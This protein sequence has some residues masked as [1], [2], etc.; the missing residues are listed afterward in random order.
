MRLRKCL[1]RLAVDGPARSLGR[2]LGPSELNEISIVA[3]LGIDESEI[4]HHISVQIVNPAEV[5]PKSSSGSKLAPVV[6]LEQE[7][8]TLP[9]ALGGLTVLTPRRLQFSHLR[10]SYSGRRLARQGLRKPLD[11]LSRYAEMRNDFFL[12][13]AKNRNASDILKTYSSMDPI[14]ANNLYTK[15]Q[16]SDE[17]VVTSKMTLNELLI[18]V[19]TKGMSAFMTGIEIV[20]DSSNTN[21]KNHQE[22]SP[23][24]NLQYSGTALFKEDRM[25][26]WL[27]ENGDEALN[28]VH[29]SIKWAAGPSALSG[30]RTATFGGICSI[31]TPR[32]RSAAKA[33]T[34]WASMSTS[35][36]NRTF[37]ISNATW[38]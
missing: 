21:E 3:G 34:T 17:H 29:D 19:E 9:D 20:G 35:R 1:P 28:Y 18:A 6:T 5:S 13:V 24:S 36:W 15:L 32:S 31:S 10:W 23:S 8:K 16:N 4:I 26:G 30:Q 11:Y 2:L 12:V 7:G 37:R 14:P 22:I 33:R 27:D 25:V 38:I